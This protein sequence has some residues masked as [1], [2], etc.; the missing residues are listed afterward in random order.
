MV[1]EVAGVIDPS[2]PTI[3]NFPPDSSREIVRDY[4]E[5]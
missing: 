3:P 2:Y 4:V 5:K 1:P